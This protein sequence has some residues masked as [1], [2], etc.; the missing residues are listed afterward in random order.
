[1]RSHCRPLAA[2]VPGTTDPRHRR[3]RLVPSDGPRVN[4]TDWAPGPPAPS[5]SSWPERRYTT[6]SLAAN[7]SSTT[8]SCSCPK[9]DEAPVDWTLPRSSATRRWQTRGSYEGHTR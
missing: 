5:A 9:A 4:C 1:M 7:T 2:M 8:R 6:E 3:P